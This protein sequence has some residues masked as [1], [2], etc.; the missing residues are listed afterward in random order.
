[1]LHDLEWRRGR[2]FL[3]RGDLLFD[4]HTKVPSSGAYNMG[5]RPI[6][7]AP[8]TAKP[9]GSLLRPNRRALCAP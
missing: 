5:M 3:P 7:E 1:M 9:A 2:P 4:E 8:G 6:P